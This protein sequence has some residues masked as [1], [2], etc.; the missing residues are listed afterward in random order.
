MF[1]PKKYN[2][3]YHQKH[4]VRI[5]KIKALYYQKNKDKIMAYH[6]KHEKKLALCAKQ[7]RER[8]M[9][10]WEGYILKK[11]KC[12]ICNKIIYFNQKDPKAAIHFDHRNGKTLIRKN[13]TH[14]LINHYR[15]PENQRIWEK[16]NFGILCRKCNAHL[17]TENRKQYLKKVIKYVF[18]KKGSI[19]NGKEKV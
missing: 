2:K 11:T 8:K 9:K 17:P 7:L 1:D 16:C 6:K 15:T 3:V 14:W 5:K 10:S 13:P 4:K 18:G 19:H 12:Q